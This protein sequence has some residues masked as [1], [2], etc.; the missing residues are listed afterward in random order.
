M[1]G[2]HKAVKFEVAVKFE[3]PNGDVS[4][5]GGTVPFR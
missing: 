4:M 3:L 5:V 1:G 2:I